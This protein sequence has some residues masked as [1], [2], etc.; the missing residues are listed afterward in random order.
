MHCRSLHQK[1][2]FPN[3]FAGS[4]LPAVDLSPTPKNKAPQILADSVA[5]E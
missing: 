3:S 4:D 5:I 1:K 2:A